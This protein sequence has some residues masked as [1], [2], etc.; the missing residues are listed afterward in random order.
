LLLFAGC[1][2]TAGAS[3]A[4]WAYRH[5]AACQRIPLTR[6]FL[7]GSQQFNPRL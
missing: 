2:T 1:A 7:L 5:S 6:E 3:P 4:I